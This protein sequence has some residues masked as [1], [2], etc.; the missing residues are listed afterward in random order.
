MR[1]NG[2]WWGFLDYPQSEPNLS[3]FLPRIE[4]ESNFALKDE[5][6]QVILGCPATNLRK[7]L[8]GFAFC[9]TLRL[10]GVVINRL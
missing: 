6:R 10:L 9:V 4:Q 7:P 1:N 8:R 3:P 2:L 5:A